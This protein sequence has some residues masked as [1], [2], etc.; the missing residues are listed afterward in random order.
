MKK[1]IK[2]KRE[3]NLLV[4]KMNHDEQDKIRPLWKYSVQT[5]ICANRNEHRIK[6][7]P[8]LTNT[9]WLQTDGTWETD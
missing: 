4:E 2:D 9:E 3:A 7:S 8:L 5:L 1:V 6:R